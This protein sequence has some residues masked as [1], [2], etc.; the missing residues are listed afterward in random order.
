L[1]IFLTAFFAILFLLKSNAQFYP[2]AEMEVGLKKI[3]T[4]EGKVSVKEFSI[5]NLITVAEF[6][7]YLLSV[8]KDSSKTFYE[9]QLPKLSKKPLELL[10]AILSDEQLQNVPMPGVSWSV[11]RNYCRWLTE[12]SANEGINYTFDLPSFGEMSAFETVYCPLKNPLL[13]TWL[14][15][16]FD[17]TMIEFS[18]TKAREYFYDALPK[19]PPAMKRKVIYGGSYHMNFTPNGN[20]PKMMYEY[21]DSSSAFI[22]FRVVRRGNTLMSKSITKTITGVS[23]QASYVNNRLNGIYSETYP[24][25]KQKALGEFYDGQRV[26]VWSVWDSTGI[27]QVQRNY[28]GSR[29]AEFL[30]PVIENPYTELY[31]KFMP[32][33]LVR[34]TDGYYPYQYVE[35]RAVVYSNRIW[36]ILN[37]SNEP[38]LFRQIDFKKLMHSILSSDLKLY[39]YGRGQFEVMVSKEKYPE[40]Q[41]EKE[42]WD[43]SRIEI[44]EDFF[45]SSDVLKGETRQLGMNF[46]V[47]P[48]DLLPAY[49]I[50]MP[51]FRKVLATYPLQLKGNTEVKNLDDYFFFKAYRGTVTK[52][53]NVFDREPKNDPRIDWEFELE[54]LMTE[55]E[56]WLQY[57][58]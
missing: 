24:N 34:N 54:L 39:E 33:D 53:S 28:N 6:K 21:Q 47:N 7:S 20:Y 22:G 26:G 23:V 9:N 30:F 5:S 16:A 8:E 1:K 4:F 11:A 10:T 15:T 27:L 57:G 58:R 49:S 19:D 56:L 14:L 48:T 29:N 3:L 2:V 38:E 35:E 36:R 43:F 25:G 46:Y 18:V 45:F 40:L 42:N 44:K 51:Q 37:P 55:H 31:K 17:E 41:K 12:K 32:T 13:E 50:Y 52:S